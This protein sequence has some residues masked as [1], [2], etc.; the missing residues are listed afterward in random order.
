MKHTPEEIIERSKKI[1]TKSG[2]GYDDEKSFKATYNPEPESWLSNKQTDTWSVYFVWGKEE[3]GK[4]R[5][6]ILYLDDKTGG[7]LLLVHTMGVSKIH[8]ETKE[9]GDIISSTG[10]KFRL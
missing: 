1:L 10:M 8:F 7:L 3:F 6:A 4:S 5:S 9:N 2:F